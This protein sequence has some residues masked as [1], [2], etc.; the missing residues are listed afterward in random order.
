MKNL[1]KLELI[2]LAYNNKGDIFKNK[3]R[4]DLAIECYDKSIKLNPNDAD[5]H[6]NKGD[7][8]DNEGKY[9]LAIKEYDKA[10]IINPNR[11]QYHHNKKITLTKKRKISKKFIFF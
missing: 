7:V 3:K 6:S 5:A 4:Y 9:D 1:T 11:S 10:I 8:L 2:A